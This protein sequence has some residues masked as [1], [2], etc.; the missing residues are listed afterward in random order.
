MQR[1]KWY[2]TTLLVMVLAL[3]TVPVPASSQV[4]ASAAT[5]GASAASIGTLASF[6]AAT[7][8]RLASIQAAPIAPADSPTTPDPICLLYGSI[9]GIVVTLVKRVGF[10]RNNPKWVALFASIIVAGASAWYHG[11]LP[12][13]ATI[14]AC[15]LTQLAG[16]VATHEVIVKPVLGT[17]AIG[18]SL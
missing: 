14:T 1:I 5:V 18:D 15:V 10:V 13:V 2:V 16:S 12:D 7:T 4:A 17:L 11:A 6:N 8:A 3:L 9:I